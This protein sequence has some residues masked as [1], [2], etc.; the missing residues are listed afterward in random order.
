MANLNGIQDSANGQAAS[1]S[2]V[3]AGEYVAA[4]VKSEM[5]E[6][7]NKPQ[8]AYLNCEFEIQ[9]GEHSGRRF[10]NMF[11][12]VNDNTIA[13]DIADRSFNSL[14][15]ACGK[16]RSSVTDSEALH[17]IPFRVK[18]TIKTDS[19]GDKNEIAGDAFK[20]L[21]GPAPQHQSGGGQQSD[22]GG[23]SAPWKRTG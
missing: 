13:K 9:D 23:K 4:L 16:L 11:N 1:S 12:L 22:Q 6:S 20:P 2:V 10:F 5:K 21:N 3:P 14:C 18:L 19:Y 15:E 17:G 8:N 7:K